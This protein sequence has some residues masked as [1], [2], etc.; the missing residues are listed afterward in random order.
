M[1]LAIIHNSEDP[2]GDSKLARAV[3][4]VI[5]SQERRVAAEVL[6]AFLSGDK[7]QQYYEGTLQPAQLNV[8]V[9]CQCFFPVSLSLS[10]F[11][12]VYISTVMSMT[13]FSLTICCSSPASCL[14]RGLICSR[15]R[16][17]STRRISHRLFSSR[18]LKIRPGQTAIVCNGRL[19]GPLGAK[20]P[21]VES[22]FLLLSRYFSSTSAEA[23][24]AGLMNVK[25]DPSKG[26]G[27]VATTSL[28]DLVVGASAVLLSGGAPKTRLTLTDHR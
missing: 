17:S 10:L 19:L 14:L 20:E 1:R 18:V 4:A 22:D 7:V 27:T 15:T 26:G 3:Q 23:I 6:E 2:H 28:A 8:E 16:K 12:S 21:F 5:D 11:R 25:P 13:V 9:C 24:M